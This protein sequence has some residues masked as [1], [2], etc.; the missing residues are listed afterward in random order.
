MKKALNHDKLI[1]FTAIYCAIAPLVLLPLHTTQAASAPGV[2]PSLFQ[3]ERRSSPL[4]YN[5]QMHPVPLQIFLDPVNANEKAALG[6]SHKGQPLKVGFARSLP[7]QYQEDIQPLLTWEIVADGGKVAAFLVHSPE[8]SG[9]RLGLHLQAFPITAELRFFN[10]TQPLQ[11]FGP[12]SAATLRARQPFW[13]PTVTGENIG[14][15]IYL[16]ASISTQFPIKIA[17][18][19]HLVYTPLAPNPKHLA[20]VG[21]SGDCE[22]DIQCQTTVPS[23]LSA[24]VAKILYINEST[25]YVCTGT[26]LTDKNDTSFIPYFMTANHCIPRQDVADTIESYWFFERAT[27]NG[28]DPTTVIQF[29]N[30]ADLL[31][32]GEETDFTLLKLRDNAISTLP[33]IHF[34]GWS[35]TDPIGRSVIGIHHPQGDIKKWSQGNADSYV[36][37]PWS[38]SGILSHIQVTWSQGVTEGGSSGSG[39]FAITGEQN[40]Q[41]L[42]VGSLHGGQSY[43]N[44]QQAPDLYGRFN[45][46]YPLVRQWLD[47]TTPIQAHLESPQTGSFESGIGL[48]RGWICDANQ[49]EMQI[50]GGVKRTVAYGTVRSD[51]QTVCGDSNNG[52]GF[53]YNW[54]LLEDGVHTLQVFA[55][56]VEFANVNFTVTT[57]GTDFLQG[58]NGDF[59]LPD[60]PQSGQNTNIRW[61]EPHQNFVII[62]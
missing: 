60:F 48:I 1:G 12:F 7:I 18:L 5:Y 15:E 36:T 41:Q 8:A 11:T 26:L 3:Y 4:K 51:T 2:S 9:I 27:C 28:A 24:A 35:S 22:I 44:D 59:A 61:S 53:T 40:N 56:D 47:V 23:N 54:N 6:V 34:A 31:A 55:D 10:L 57:L 19:Q 33:G 20:Q 49:I 14:V 52:F 25:S 45:L 16:P 46:T 50:D 62:P 37:S 38:S 17:N 39:I 43:C 13:S 58:V 42:F 32:T 21:R 30:G 29:S